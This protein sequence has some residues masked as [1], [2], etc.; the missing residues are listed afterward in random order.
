MIEKEKRKKI[1]SSIRSGKKNICFPSLI[2]FKA[3]S[4]I[5][6]PNNHSFDSRLFP[7]YPLVLI[8]NKK[9][10]KISW[11]KSETQR[12]ARWKG[13]LFHDH[14]IILIYRDFNSTNRYFFFFFYLFFVHPLPSFTFGRNKKGLIKGDSYSRFLN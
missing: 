11:K 3:I 2:N 9:K 10:K 13:L 7:T 14:P 6:T 1:G 8:E 4:I 5:S 12:E